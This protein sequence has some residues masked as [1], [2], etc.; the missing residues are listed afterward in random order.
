M[1]YTQPARQPPQVSLAGGNGPLRRARTAIF[2]WLIVQLADG[3]GMVERNP[4]AEENVKGRLDPSIEDV[5]T[6]LLDTKY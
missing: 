1:E 6:R 3:A 2:M 4:D 5:I